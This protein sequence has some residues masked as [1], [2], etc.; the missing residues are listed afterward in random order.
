MKQKTKNVILIFSIQFIHFFVDL[1]AFIVVPLALLFV[2]EKN[3]HLPR[4]FRWYETYDYDI[5]GDEPW[6]GWEHANGKQRTYWW[7]LRWLLRNRVGT[8]SYEHMGFDLALVYKYRVVGDVYTNNRPGHSGKL[9]AEALLHDGK[10]VIPSY[11]YVRQW[12][13]SGRCLRAYAGWKFRRA[14]PVNKW[15]EQGLVSFVCTV[16][17][18]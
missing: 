12:G 9:Y 16:N 15:P 13:K 7:R 3:N 4:W 10:T 18:F 8:F 14:E 2:S 6:Q 11:Y 1:S 5:N 17:P